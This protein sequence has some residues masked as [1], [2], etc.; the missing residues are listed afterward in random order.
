[1][2]PLWNGLQPSPSVCTTGTGTLPTTPE[3]GVILQHL[4]ATAIVSFYSYILYCVADLLHFEEYNV[5][6]IVITSPHKW[7][8]TRKL[9]PFD[10]VIMSSRSRSSYINSN[11]SSGS[12]RSS[13]SSSSSGGSGSWSGNGTGSGS[14]SGR[15]PSFMSK[16]K[17]SSEIGIKTIHKQH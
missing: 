16:R 17:Y 15:L 12:I 1:M 4:I 7:P 6:R 13:S 9:F 11:R 8:V 5:R 10:A 2:Y 3:P 14:G